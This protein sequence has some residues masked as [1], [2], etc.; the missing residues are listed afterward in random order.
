MPEHRYGSVDDVLVETSVEAED[1]PDLSETEFGDL[2]GL[3]KALLDEATSLIDRY[4]NRDFAHHENETASIDGNGRDS[5]QLPR[6]WPIIEIHSIEVGG[7]ELPEDEYRVK[8][9][10]NLSDWNS[11]IIERKNS[12]WPEGWENIEI[13]LDWGFEETPPAID[14]LAEGI[15]SDAILEFMA[16]RTTGGADNISMDGFSITLPDRGRRD[17]D[18][19]TILDQ[20]SA[21]QFG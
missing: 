11:G 17:E 2:D 20:F 21:I 14:D 19:V 6:Q 16:N 12:V 15:V 13:E 8:P 9:G 3:I 18:Q 5:I 1:L 10:R 4:T 7:N